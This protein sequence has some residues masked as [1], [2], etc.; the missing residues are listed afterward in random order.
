MTTPGPNHLTKPNL[1]IVVGPGCLVVDRCVPGGLLASLPLCLGRIPAPRAQA[2]VS[3]R[4]GVG[5]VQMLGNLALQAPQPSRTSH[6]HRVD[7]TPQLGGN[8]R[9]R[10][11]LIGQ[12]SDLVLSP[13]ALLYRLRARLARRDQTRGLLALQVSNVLDRPEGT[14]QPASRFSARHRPIQRD[15]DLVRRPFPVTGN[16]SLGHPLQLGSATTF[17]GE[18]LLNIAAPVPLS[19][20]LHL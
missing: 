19:G 5:A 17:L 8:L 6:S 9:G 2:S 14:P 13:E 12:D 18:Q 11:G 7:R 3:A 4:A 1:D 15:R 10:A 16:V 20:L